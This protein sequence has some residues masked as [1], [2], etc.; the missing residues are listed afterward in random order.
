MIQNRPLKEETKV[1]EQPLV[2]KPKPE[3]IRPEI[4]DEVREKLQ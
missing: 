3:K 1:V 4:C 2:E